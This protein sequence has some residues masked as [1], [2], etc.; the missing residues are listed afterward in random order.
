M[1]S[2]ITADGEGRLGRHAAAPSGHRARRLQPRRLP[3]TSA[4]GLDLGASR[5]DPST[6]IAGDPVRPRR[7]SDRGGLTAPR[8]P[9]RLVADVAD[10]RRRIAEN[11]PRPSP[12]D[13]RNRRG[14]LVDLEFIVQ[15]LMLREAAR[16]PE[17][18]RR[19]AGAALLA[20]GA[21]AILPPQGVRELGDAL[22]LMRHVR[23]LLALLFEG[24]R[25]GGSPARPA[26]PWR[27]A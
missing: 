23:A 25:T 27:A 22:A 19:E 7:S 2:A 9:G 16:M 14:G 3:N 26:P 24:A 4:I 20:L 11:F 17:V 13:L 10:M 18:L 5:T 6:P 8:D 15:Y 12:W 21:A 1:I